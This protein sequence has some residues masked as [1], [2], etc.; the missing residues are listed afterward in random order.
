MQSFDDG[1][2]QDAHSPA[3][4]RHPVV[5]WGFR[6]VCFGHVSPLDV[7]IGTV[8]HVDG[9]ELLVKPDKQ[10]VQAPD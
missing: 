5:F 9:L 4:G 3:Q 2:V 8:V 1:P 7:K 6:N 10:V